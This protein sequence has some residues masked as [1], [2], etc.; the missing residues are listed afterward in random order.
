MSNSIQYL[1]SRV[2]GDRY[3]WLVVFVLSVFSILAVY[4]ST[5]TLAYRSAGGNTEYYLVKHSVILLFGIVLMY[6]SHLIPYKYYSR[7]AQILLWLSVPA[8]LYTMFLA[9]EVNDASRWITLPVINLTF[10]TSDLA[11][12][13][14]IMYTARVLSKKQ[15]KVDSFKEAFIPVIL[16]IA[17]IC[18]LILPE[19][20]S[21][22]SV[23]FF[24]C[25]VLMFVGRVKFKYILL[26]IGAGIVLI[27]LI[28]AL[29]YAFPH[30]GRMGTW[31]ARVDSFVDGGTS[32]DTYQVDQA[33]I[34]IAK[35]GVFGVGPGNSTQ[36]DFLPYP[37]ADF[38][39]ATILEE[40]GLMGG[41]FV[42]FLY[43][44][45]LY[46]CIKIVV[47]APTSFGALLAVGLGLCLCIQAFINMGVAVHLLPTTGLTLPLVSM[48]GTSL[49][50]TS[51]SIGIIL[52][53]SREIEKAD[54]VEEEDEQTET[55]EQSEEEPEL[56]K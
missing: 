33:K 30:V 50:F 43:L 44:V 21:T 35:G 23:L 10:Q 11:R 14:L 6:L 2:R 8:L 56:A 46:R 36:K 4:S 32:D 47:K 41:I 52:S 31:K 16:P 9:P 48:G 55:E 22:A 18:A 24:T 29:A 1:F 38:I 28:I 5:E 19:N 49:W 51:L 20:L 3:I 15:D 37:Y 13:A 27:G 40:Y 54:E 26:T 53:V 34:A 25:I 42:I 39:F 17:I 45:F 7:I 12:F